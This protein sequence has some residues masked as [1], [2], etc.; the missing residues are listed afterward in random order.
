MFSKKKTTQSTKNYLD[1]IDSAAK[2]INDAEKILIGVGSGL[3][4]AG[5]LNYTD[6]DLVKKWFPEYYSKGFRS[7]FEIQGMCWNLKI[8]KPESYWGYWSR[9]IW[10]IRYE[11]ECLKP[12]KDLYN[13][14]RNKDYFI[15]STNV[16]GQL[17][18]A[19]FPKEKIFAPQG[20]YA[21]FQC[22]KPCSNDVY[23]NREM[24]KR[25]IENMPSSTKICKED[26]PLC[27]KCGAPLVPNLR[28][29]DT[30]VEKPHLFNEDDYDDFIEDSRQK[31]IILLEL[32]VG[33]NTPV[34]IR[35]PFDM[36][37][38][39]F[40]NANLIRV[41]L[42]YPEVPEEIESKSIS[43]QEDIAK[44]LNDMLKLII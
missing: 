1:K 43:F 41:N 24:V 26:I 23:D 27:P 12:Y 44:T 3:S 34:I 30:F 28:C 6:A 35:Y 9:H 21:L 18:K 38:R 31:H 2:L 11:T 5:G 20:D 4:A 42:S 36:I 17:E 39:K 19:G 10:H 29:D 37:A 40:I 8:C 13:L 33:F 15:C 14:M 25:M 22:S 32:G 7:I 16:D